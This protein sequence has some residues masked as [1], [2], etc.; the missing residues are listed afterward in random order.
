[1]SESRARSRKS[2]TPEEPSDKEK[3]NEY[4][5]VRIKDSL[6]G[7]RIAH[8]LDWAAQNMPRRYFHYNVICQQVNELS[9]TPPKDDKQ[10]ELVRRSMTSAKRILLKRYKRGADAQ[11]E[12]GVRAT[13]DDADIVNRP[14]VTSVSKEHRA[15]Q[16]TEELIALVDKTKL[17]PKERAY[18]LSVVKTARAI[19]QADVQK[20]LPPKK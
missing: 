18:F 11:R 4:R 3:L 16:R 9:K 13:S 10:V 2:K 8:F 14:L 17:P 5:Q 15:H 19:D 12:L 1:M 20:L 7:R 6:L